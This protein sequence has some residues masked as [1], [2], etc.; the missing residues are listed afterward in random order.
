MKAV[1]TQKIKE[2]KEAISEVDKAAKVLQKAQEAKL[3]E[4]ADEVN[5]VLEKHGFNLSIR[6]EFT[7]IPKQ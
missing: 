5:S 6:Y 3:K 1:K 2:V 4:C 7:L